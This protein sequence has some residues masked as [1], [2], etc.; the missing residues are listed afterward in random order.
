[1]TTDVLIP[2]TQDE[3]HLAAAMEPRFLDLCGTFKR[4]R[5]IELPIPKAMQAA[6]VLWRTA[7]VR[8]KA[9]DFRVSDSERKALKEVAQWTLD[10]N[11]DLRNQ[12]RK[13]LPWTA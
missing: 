3:V 6:I 10:E 11:C 9:G 12:P 1:M 7:V 4:V 8:F 13:K 2:A 5:G